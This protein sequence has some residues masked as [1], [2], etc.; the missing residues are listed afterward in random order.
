MLKF[1]SVQLEKYWTSMVCFKGGRRKSLFSKKQIWQHSLDLHST[2]WINHK[3]DTVIQK[4]MALSS[5]CYRWFYMLYLFYTHYTSTFVICYMM[6]I[7]G[8]ICLISWPEKSYTIFLNMQI[9]WPERSCVFFLAQLH[10]IFPWIH[11]FSVISFHCYVHSLVFLFP[12]LLTVLNLTSS[13]EWNDYTLN[14]K[15]WWFLI[16]VE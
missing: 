12:C 4:T 16:S 5:C 8:C 6:I 9:L 3:V 15:W 11:G 10:N 14:L 1:K 13:Q 2:I 7:S